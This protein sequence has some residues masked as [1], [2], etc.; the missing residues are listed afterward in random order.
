VGWEEEKEEEEE[1]LY[2]GSPFLVSFEVFN[3]N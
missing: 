1:K 2:T 3:V